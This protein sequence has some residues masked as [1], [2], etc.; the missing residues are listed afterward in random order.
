MA[1]DKDH[2]TL[3]ECTKADLLWIINRMSVMHGAYYLE[4]AL[5]ELWYEKEKQRI[6]EADKYRKIV[7][8]KTRAY[9][10]LMQPYDGQFYSSIPDSVIHKA[11]KLT[12]EAD[13]AQKKFMSLMGIKLKGN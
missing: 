4:R 8:E 3:N 11:A 10:D 12:R 6:A 2:I 1:K 5:N 9:N 7:A 13:A